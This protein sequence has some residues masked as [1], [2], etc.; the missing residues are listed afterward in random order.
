MQSQGYASDVSVPARS[1]AEALHNPPL[2]TTNHFVSIRKIDAPPG[3]PF[4]MV[5]AAWLIAADLAACIISLLTAVFLLQPDSGMFRLVM[6][7]VAIALVHVA[8]CGALGQY[9]R[10]GAPPSLPNLP[11]TLAIWP[12]AA[13]GVLTFAWAIMDG[14][15]WIGTGF[16]ALT[17]VS[18]AILL[19]LSRLFVSRRLR[20]EQATGRHATR[21]VLVG[22]V[23]EADRMAERLRDATRSGAVTVV[24][25]IP[26][27][28]TGGDMAAIEAEL[29][30]ILPTL[31]VTSVIVCLPRDGLSHLIPIADALR[32]FPV[33]ILTDPALLPAMPDAAVT[34]GGQ[35]FVALSRRPLHDW[36]AVAKR[37]EDVVLGLAL[38]LVTLPVMVMIAV[39]IRL[40]SRGPVMIRQR[41]F[42]YA[43]RSVMVFKFRTM[44]WDSGD[45]TGARATIPGDPRVTRLGR[46]LRS[47]SLDELPQ[48]FNVLAGDMSLVGPRPHPVEMRVNGVHYHKAVRHYAARHRMKPGIT[49]LAQVNGYRGLVDTME[50][51]EGRLAYDLQ[52][53]ENW[54]IAAD[55]GILARTVSKGFTGDS[56]F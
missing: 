37:A 28:A 27:A 44:Y 50:K 43:N 49:G 26:F 29:E 39:A 12:A 53:V 3:M 48:L 22:S 34:L 7:S 52:Y 23:P 6:V 31:P 20:A 16:A 38:T 2:Q 18:G 9:G 33:D 19:I 14:A 42:G 11:V 35:R 21:V 54:S 17:L 56:A 4:S 1:T 15:P 13:G 40:S 32:D 51:A 55:L 5:A 8:A 45:P 41:R 24:D 46:F 47:S 36:R 30:A 10:N 25:I